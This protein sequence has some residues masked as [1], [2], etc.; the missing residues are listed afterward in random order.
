MEDV[1]SFAFSGIYSLLILSLTFNF[2]LAIRVHILD[3]K[4]YD[5]DVRTKEE[6]KSIKRRMAKVK[7]EI[8][9]RK[10]LVM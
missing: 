3:R 7:E 5:L 6:A 4:V 8:L 2:A 10:G 1:L 9:E